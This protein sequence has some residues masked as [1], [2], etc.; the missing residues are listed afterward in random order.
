M[1]TPLVL[2]IDLGTES[3]R[4]E[5][6]SPDG[7][8]VAAG[9]QSYR[10]DFPGAGWA[11]QNPRDWWAALKDALSQVSAKTRLAE[12]RALAV[13]ATSS[14]VVA[15]T[16]A[17]EPLAPALL[18]M[19]SRA[20]EETDV[21]NATRH[22]VLRFAGGQAS[23]E[24]IVPKTLWLKR[25]RPDLWSHPGLKVVEA[26]DWLNFRL[27]GRW[28][29]ARCNAVCKGLYGEA[30]WDSRFL[31][32]IGLEDYRHVWPQDVVAL[33][34]PLERLSPA[35]ASELGLPGTALVVQGAI[36]AHIGMLGMGITEAGQLAI[37]MGTSF[38][39]LGLS[40]QPHFHPG[41]WGPYPEPIYSGM[42]LLEGGQ[43]SAGSITRWFRDRLAPDLPAA[44]AYARLTAEAAATPPGADGLVLLDYWQGNRTPLREPRLSGAVW[45]LRLHH[46]RGHL[47]R[48]VLEGVACGTRHVLD[49]FAEAGYEVRQI[50]AGGGVT[51][52]PLWLQILADV[53][54]RPLQLA[55]ASNTSVTGAAVAAAAGAGMY[56]NVAAAARAMTAYAGMVE[57][58][59]H[60]R[61]VYDALYAR[62]RETSER[63]AP[64]MTSQ[65]AG[66]LTA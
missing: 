32:A 45:G 39:H 20:V 12:V 33:G 8:R 15:C 64:L 66:A 2:G 42:W 46:T 16:S 47:Y 29:A 35:A 18:W 50:V 17:G 31:E 57:P 14:T 5:A 60:L 19:D 61:S 44:E 41:L 55:A 51:R 28:A 10:T 48:A 26:V 34:E 3:V 7:I 40:H 36:D 9:E 56:E 21:I 25:H 22:P 52:N 11:E 38:V 43:I 30:G 62:Y 49:A 59:P 58:Q 13:S 24:W 54:G 37:T 63:L 23:P 65:S 27:T 6:L 1:S 53:T 4:V